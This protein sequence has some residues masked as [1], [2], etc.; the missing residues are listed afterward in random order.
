MDRILKIYDTVIAISLLLILLVVV[1]IAFNVINI[2]VEIPVA[3]GICSAI[4]L[5]SFV[6]GRHDYIKQ[7]K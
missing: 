1:Q 2:T 5:V 3:I 4:G 7:R 6:V